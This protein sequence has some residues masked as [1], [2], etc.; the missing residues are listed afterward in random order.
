M[1]IDLSPSQVRAL[2]GILLDTLTRP[3]AVRVHVDVVEQ[4]ETTP[5]ELLVLLM[6][7]LAPGQ[8]VGD[9][10]RRARADLRAAQIA[11]LRENVAAGAGHECEE[12]FKDGK[13]QLCDREGTPR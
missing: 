10:F 5:E 4:V 3:D 7:A 9:D 6:D 12:W 11:H 8:H 2:T 1:M 13:C